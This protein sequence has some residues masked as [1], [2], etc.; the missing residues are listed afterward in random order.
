[1][2]FYVEGIGIPG[3]YYLFSDGEFRFAASSRPQLK[4]EQV[5]PVEIFSYQARDGLTIPTL[6][7]RPAHIQTKA[8]LP[9]VML[10]HGGPEAYDSKGFDWLAQYFASRGFLVIQPQFRGS[11]GFG[12]D[13]VLQGRGQWGKKMQDDLTD[14]VKVLAQQGQLDANRV[15]I[16]GASYG[17]YAALAGAT[18]TPDLYQCAVSI[19]GVADLEMMLDREKRE[20]RRRGSIVAYWE[21]AMAN[22]NASDAYLE[23]VSP[24]HHAAKIDA[25]I[26]LIHGTIDEVVDIEQSEDMYST[27]KK[28]GK[29]VTFIEL[30]DEG[31]YLSRNETRLQ[32]L[33]AIDQFIHRHIN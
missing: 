24:I 7:T 20:H 18:F 1:M 27:L 2:L 16:V 21:D 25:P 19:N 33:Q 29:E 32:T 17:G 5:N 13:H 14:A 4:P 6:L 23:S 11:W 26:L 28:L 9:A 8:P 31:H 10:P 30:D 15:C 22:G 3:E 12:L